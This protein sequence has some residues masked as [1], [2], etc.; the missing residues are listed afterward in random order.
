MIASQQSIALEYTLTA[1]PILAYN[2]VDGVILGA[3]LFYYPEKKLEKSESASL[4]FLANKDKHDKAI[5]DY[6]KLASNE[7][8]GFALSASFDNFDYAEYDDA[9][10]ANIKWLVPSGLIL[11]HKYY[12]QAVNIMNGLCFS[13]WGKEM[14]TQLKMNS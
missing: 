11:N 4:R 7:T 13:I 8:Y 6:K 9:S 3:A 14:K 10:R 2:A 5:I 12:S 1:S